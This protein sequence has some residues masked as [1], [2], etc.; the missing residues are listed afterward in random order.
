MKLWQHVYFTCLPDSLVQVTIPKDDQRGFPPKFKRHLLGIA[1]R[2]A[3]LREG[4][5]SYV[6]GY[7]SH[8]HITPTND[9]HTLPPTCNATSKPHPPLHDLFAHFC[10][11]SEAYLPHIQVVHKCLSHQAPLPR[12]D[13]D[14]PRGETCLHRQL[15]KFECSQR[16][17]LT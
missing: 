10:R 3:G 6:Y 13:I 9:N 5:W 1:D 8:A 15:G 7:M 12:D 17:D 14:D 4:V 11:P 16:S 2:T